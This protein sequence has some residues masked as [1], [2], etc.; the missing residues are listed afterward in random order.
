M[1]PSQMG[2]LVQLGT[3]YVTLRYV[4]GKDGSMKNGY[5]GIIVHAC[6][7]SAAATSTSATITVR[8]IIITTGI[9]YRIEFS[10]EKPISYSRT[11]Y[12][13]FLFCFHCFNLSISLS[14]SLSQHL[15]YQSTPKQ[16]KTTNQQT[17]KQ[18]LRPWIIINLVVRCHVHPLQ[19]CHFCK[20]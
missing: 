10:K 13:L 16:N 12:T 9:S 17:N 7:L 1:V 11:P 14:L 3:F 5:T 20:C 15:T 4:H 6:I 8:C 19:T 2:S 18:R